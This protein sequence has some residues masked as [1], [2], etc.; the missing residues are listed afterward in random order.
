MKN[1]VLILLSALTLGACSKEDALQQEMNR[2]RGTWNLAEITGGIA[3]T[4]YEADFAQL[5]MSNRNRYRL[6]ADG[7]S[8]QEGDY[9]LTIEEEELV[10][11]FTPNTPDNVNF[12][13]FEK[14][15]LWQNNNRTLILSEP[16]C[17]LFVYNFERTQ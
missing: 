7:A 3:G 17:D 5:E 4:G 13:E 1:A 8:I 9:E 14:T 11:R 15:I 10:I 12:D 6:L 16:C 2:L